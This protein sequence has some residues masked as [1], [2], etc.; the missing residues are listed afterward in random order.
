MIGGG[1]AGY[2]AAI[3]AATA[4]PGTRVVLLE[5][6]HKPLAKVKI[7]GGGR[8]NVTHHCQHVAELVKHY[9]RGGKQLRSAFQYFAAAQT[10]A[11]FAERGVALK[12][13][14]DGRMFP[15]TDSSQIVID[16]LQQAA[17][18]SGVQVRLGCDVA[19]LVPESGRWAV[20]LA[21]GTAL[22]ADR[23]VVATGGSPKADGLKWLA[24]LGHTV[25]APVPS[26]FTFNMPGNPIR[27]LMGVTAAHA[28]VRIT[29]KK[30][31]AEG[32][33]LIT[34][35]GMSGPAVLKLSAWG[36]RDLAEMGYQF[37][38][39]VNWVPLMDE[40]QVKG[41]LE[42]TMR[43]T[44]D[45]HMGNKNPFELPGRLWVFLLEKALLSTIQPWK[46][47]NGK[48][49]NRLVNLLTNDTYPVRGKTTF[50]EEF[51][52]AGGVALESVQ[53]PTMQSKVCP[54]LFFA[55]E[56]LDIDGVTGGFNFQAAWTTGFLAGM[57]AAT[58]GR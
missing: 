33:L 18:A 34:H 40:S 27:E 42:K 56:V 54:G 35:W 2:F 37:N 1:A 55:G 12:V 11:W 16:C 32:P 4:V 36:A 7:S 17:S 5:K 39:Q 8:C 29:G 14:E 43:E 3:H 26:L 47:L 22:L 50:K 46:A 52:T 48:G 21:K 58:L 25:V 24:D 19:A 57:H 13:E 41:A 38:C 20:H 15:V 31:Q 30:L 28:R 45:K 23:V 6:T 44:P 10:I 9:P 51:V 53:F 49:I